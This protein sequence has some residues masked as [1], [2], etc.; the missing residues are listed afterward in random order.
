MLG[1]VMNRIA[2]A[3]IIFAISLIA[4]ASLIENGLVALGDRIENGLMS[5]GDKGK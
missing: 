1:E 5:I 4:S 3:I 2:I